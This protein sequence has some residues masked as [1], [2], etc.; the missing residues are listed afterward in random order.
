MVRHSTH[1]VKAFGVWA[2]F[3]ITL[4]T[5]LLPLPYTELQLPAE[6]GISLFTNDIPYVCRIACAI[7]GNF[8]YVPVCT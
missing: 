6:E 5:S 3:A 4:Q 2:S 8:D 1:T 7:I